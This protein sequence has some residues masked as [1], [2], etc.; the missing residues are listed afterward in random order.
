MAIQSPILSPAMTYSGSISKRIR[1]ESGWGDKICCWYE[2]LY[3]VSENR[4]AEI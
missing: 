3:V 1:L 2:M 4:N